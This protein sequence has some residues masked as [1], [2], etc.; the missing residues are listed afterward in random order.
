MVGKPPS[1][2]FVG[3]M[4]VPG[5]GWLV[6]NRF[7][8]DGSDV[9]FILGLGAILAIL[10]TLSRVTLTF[11]PRMLGAAPSIG[12]IGAAAAVYVSLL[13]SDWFV[14]VERTFTFIVQLAA[15]V[16]VIAVIVRTTF[17]FS[18]P[19]RE[20]KAFEVRACAPAILTVAVLFVPAVYSPGEVR[21][22]LSRGELDEYART[23]K[24]G[25]HCHEPRW[26]GLYRVT[27]GARFGGTVSLEIDEPLVP[28]DGRP[29]LISPDFRT[30]WLQD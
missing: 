8:E 5:I 23:V 7:A 1:A 28:T 18:T 6:S 11:V 25:E 20:A 15:F 2:W 3:I 17:A 12:F 21:L 30:T 26:V 29:W 14:A 16:T 22:E 10:V 9:R 13:A 24:D 19:R 27:C 4:L